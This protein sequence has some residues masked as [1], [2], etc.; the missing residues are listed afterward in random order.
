MKSG[1]CKYKRDVDNT[2]EIQWIPVSEG[3][4]DDP[5]MVLITLQYENGDYEIG[6][7]EYWKLTDYGMEKYPEEYG[8][9]RQHKNVVAWAD[10]PSPYIKIS[11]D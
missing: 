8:F 10:L 1:K 2:R 6:I 9:G 7:A 3:Y 4:P 11:N 5:R